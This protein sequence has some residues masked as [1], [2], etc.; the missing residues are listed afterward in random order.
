MKSA[1][2]RTIGI[3]LKKPNE[4][5]PSKFYNFIFISAP[6]PGT[7]ENIL[8]D[9]AGFSDY[10]KINDKRKLFTLTTKRGFKFNNYETNN[11]YTTTN[12]KGDFKNN[13]NTKYYSTVNS[14]NN[15]FEE[16]N[17]NKN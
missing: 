6:G 17:I 12:L 11:C 15:I 3:K 8:T 16:V 14:K 4:K 1:T 10:N 5:C 9:F 7:Y 2:S 13:I